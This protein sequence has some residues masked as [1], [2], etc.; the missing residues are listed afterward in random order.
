MINCCGIHLFEFFVCSRYY[1][2]VRPVFGKDLHSSCWPCILVIVFFVLQ[3]LCFPWHPVSQFLL[4]FHELMESF[5]ESSCIFLY[6]E[7]FSLCIEVKSL[8]STRLSILSA[9][10]FRVRGNVLISAFSV[11]IS[12]FPNTTCLK[13]FFSLVPL[14]GVLWLN[15]ILLVY[16]FVFVFVLVPAPILLL[17]LWL[18]QIRYYDLPPPFSCSKLFL[19]SGPLYFH[20]NLR[21]AS[22]FLWW[23]SLE[24]L[25]SWLW[26]CRSLFKKKDF[27]FIYM[28]IL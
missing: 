27:I 13:R 18:C 28:G 1:S 15:V 12:G 4:V 22:Y 26:V 19:M 16:S 11:Q 2:P 17:L 24:F 21:I 25:Q 10:S 3:K 14:S 9:F 23:M 8:W 5:S 6:M 7:V 20:M